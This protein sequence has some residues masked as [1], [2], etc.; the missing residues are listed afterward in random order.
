LFWHVAALLRSAEQSPVIAYK[1]MLLDEVG[2]LLVIC[3]SL[4]K[5]LMMKLQFSKFEMFF[6]LG[7]LMGVMWCQMLVP[8]LILVD[9]MEFD[10]V[11]LQHYRAVS[12]FC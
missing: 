9:H 6:R 10:M 4:L 7:Y 5:F 12:N 8:V 3:Y 2:I 1:A 11:H